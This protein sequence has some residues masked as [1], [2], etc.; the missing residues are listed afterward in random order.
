MK[1]DFTPDPSL[2]P[3]EQRWFTSYAGQMH[4]VDEGG[5]GR[6][7]LFCHGNPTW[8]FLYRNVITRLRG[9]FRCI[10][11]DYLGFGLS[12]RPEAYGYTIEEHARCVGELVDYLQLDG[13]ITMGQDWGGPVSMAV[14]TARAERVRGVILGNTWFWPVDQLGTKL[15]SRVMSTAWM[16][17]QILLRP[18]RSPWFQRAEWN[19]APVKEARPGRSGARQVR[20]PT[21]R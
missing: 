9:H 13:F 8:S 14:G 12:E 19:T 11:V 7:I 6:P 17:R 5:A 1:I 15:V 10:A 2:Y 18:V 16:Q 4:Y 3:F 21:G 20:G